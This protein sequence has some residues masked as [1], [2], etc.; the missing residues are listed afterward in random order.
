MKKTIILF[1]FLFTALVSNS[2]S[3]PQMSAWDGV[4]YAIKDYYK[5][6]ANDPGSIKYEEASLMMKFNNGKF[7]QRVKLRGKNAFGATMLNE[8]YFIITG[9][10]QDAKVEAIYD[11]SEFEAYGI[12]NNI[13]IVSKYDS[14]GKMVN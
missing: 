2:Q 10:G 1:L 7:S 13:K 8:K 6:N 11:A 4:A 3:I 14:N 9:T 12:K 5:Q